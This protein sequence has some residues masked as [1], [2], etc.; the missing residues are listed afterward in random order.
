MTKTNTPID[1]FF[2]LSRG[3][4]VQIQ[5]GDLAGDLTSQIDPFASTFSFTPDSA[6]RIASATDAL[7]NT[8]SFAYD[9]ADNL[10]QITDLNGAIAEVLLRRSWESEAQLMR[11]S[12]P[13]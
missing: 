10:T 5:T 13:Q 1:R 3:C 9:A 4:V 11:I 12:T 8:T 2:V 7:R 6:G